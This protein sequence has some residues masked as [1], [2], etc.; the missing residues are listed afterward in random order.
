MMVGI[1]DWL[2][3]LLSALGGAVGSWVAVKVSVTRLE[4]QMEQAKKSVESHGV[5]IQRYGDDLLIHDLEIETALA[6]L[7]LARVRRQ[8]LRE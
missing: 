3:P 2:I 6:K 5:D 4:V 8:R 1:P 7:G